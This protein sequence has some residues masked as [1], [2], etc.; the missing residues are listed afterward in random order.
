MSD[1]QHED[2]VRRWAEKLFY[3]A[4]L[5][6]KRPKK[7]ATAE[8]LGT[9]AVKVLSGH[10]QVRAQIARTTQHSPEVIVK[11]TNRQGAGKGMAAIRKHLIYIS[12]HGKLELETDTGERLQDMEAISDFAREL[13]EQVRGKPIPEVSDRREA[14]NLT[15][16]M[17]VGTPPDKVREAAKRFLEDEFE[18]RHRYCFT[19][20]TDTDNPHVHACVQR[21]PMK[22][23]KRLR[24]WL[25]DFRRWR[26][27]FAGELRELGID[28]NATSRRTRG[29]TKKLIKQSG[30]HA[31]KRQALKYT[32]LAAQP[33]EWPKFYKGTLE[34]WQRM[35]KSLKESS[36]EADRN[37]AS[38]IEKF[39]SGQN[40]E[41]RRKR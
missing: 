6:G 14:F 1:S 31:R 32:S 21:A 25:S 35:A 22:K 9:M 34:A 16:S 12:R 37:A 36:S 24:P 38:L 41:I 33:V 5:K 29:V 15:L 2:D 28:A 30:Y 10:A 4:S 23:A 27:G 19:L 20:H 18:G 26:E 39:I 7:D 13:Q 8:K 40:P 17:P 3:P 11:I